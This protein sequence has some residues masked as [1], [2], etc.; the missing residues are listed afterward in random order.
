MRQLIA[1]LL[2]F[3]LMA[4]IPAAGKV[5]LKPQKKP[6][7]P[8]GNLEQFLRRVQGPNL[9]MTHSAGSLWPLDGSSNL[10]D[11]ATDYKA[12]HAGDL[13]MIRIVEQTLATAS[14]SVN[15]QRSFAASSGITALAGKINT[16]GVQQL[17]S[18]TSSSALKGA[19]TADSQSQLQANLAGRVVAVMPNGNMVIEAERVVSFNQQ[20]QTVVL[21]GL[22]RPGDLASD[23]SVLSTSISDLELELKGKGVVTDA[24]RQ[25]NLFM[26]LLLK[27]VNF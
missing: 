17:F 25:P 22:I 14:G 2:L 27:L 15:G 3:L 4:A 5:H 10:T 12:R 11:L 6:L 13:V 26:R 19:G 20:T 9:S 8:P 1:R 7:T 21:R 23:N 24:T 18:P 16:A